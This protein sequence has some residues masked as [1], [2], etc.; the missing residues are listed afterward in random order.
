MTLET[1]TETRESPLTVKLSALAS[2][3]SKF[4]YISAIL[5]VLISFFQ[6]AILAQGFDLVKISAYFSDS[7]MVISDIISSLIIGIVVIV[8]AVPEGL[9]L[10]IAI[11]CSPVS[12]THLDV[13]KRQELY[14]AN[15]LMQAERI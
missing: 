5:I 14:Y 3:I 6:N 10:M 13:Y 12:Y 7:G 4:G 15:K 1:Q 2:S 9:P 11:V 8:V